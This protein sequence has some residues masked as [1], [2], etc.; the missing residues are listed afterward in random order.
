MF[1][2]HVAKGVGIQRSYTPQAAVKY[3]APGRGPAGVNARPR[4]MISILRRTKRVVESTK[5]AT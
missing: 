5:E 4:L 2:A 3:P 1:E